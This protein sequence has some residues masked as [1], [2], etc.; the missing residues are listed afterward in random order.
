MTGGHTLVVRQDNL[1]DVLLAGPCVRAVA[2]GSDRVTLLVGPRGRAAADLLPDVDDIVEWEAPWIDPEPSWPGQGAVLDVVER[3]RRRRVDRAVILTSFHQSPLPTA[4]VL[5]LA[6]VPW[7]AGLSDDY[8]GALLDVR[9]RV[10]DD[11]PE[12]ERALSL[13]GRAGFHLPHGDDG[14]L[15]LRPALPR[16]E[17]LVGP[18]PY[19]VVHPGASA[20]ARTASRDWWAR[21]VQALVAR[22]RRVVVTGGPDE[23]AFTGSVAADYAEDLGGRTSFAELA[24]VLRHAD[25]TVAPNTGAAHLSAAVGTPV[26]SMFAPLVPVERWQ[27]YGVRC[28]VLGDQDAPCRGTRARVCRLDAHPCLDAISAHRV[29]AAVAALAAPAAAGKSPAASLETP[30]GGNV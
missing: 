23:T 1:G 9:H 11:V 12:P 15:R 10:D 24:A 21:A 16:V 25:V 4:L 30:T 29:C 14:T 22:G 27:P 3:I 17:Q 7:I 6:G 28:I 26:V 20:P 18:G 2:A 5:R 19:V 13:A 8:P